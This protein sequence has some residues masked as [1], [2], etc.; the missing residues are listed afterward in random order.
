M[1]T[2][3][4]RATLRRTMCGFSAVLAITVVAMLQPSE[5]HAQINIGKYNGG[6]F[7]QLNPNINLQIG[8]NNSNA[9]SQFGPAFSQGGG[10]IFAPFQ[11]VNVNSS[12]SMYQQGYPYGL[13]ATPTPFLPS[14]QMP[15]VVGGGGFQA[16]MM[17]GPGGASLFN[18]GAQSMPVGGGGPIYLPY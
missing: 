9:Q 2:L 13:G 17:S 11:G 12:T 14:G 1:Q 5:A 15:G 6:P 7:L 4:T 3:V 8:N 16:P 10:N 18:V